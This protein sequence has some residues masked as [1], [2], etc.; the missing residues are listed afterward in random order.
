MKQTPNTDEP[1]ESQNIVEFPAQDYEDG[2]FIPE[3]IYRLK[4]LTHY[5]A[6]QFGTPKLILVFKVVDFGQYFG[7]EIK[8]YFNVAEHLGKV[9]SKGKVRHKRT[10]DFMVQYY[11]VLY[12]H[13]PYRLDRVPMEPLYNAVIVGKVRTVKTNRDRKKL[14]E[15]LFYSKVDELIRIE[16]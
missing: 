14:P 7:T 6:V 4:L 3:G 15:Q 1:I 10:G 2:A 12:R 9:G 8:A 16:N 13:R 11:T 5:T